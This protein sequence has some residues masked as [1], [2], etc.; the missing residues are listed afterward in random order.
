[1]IDA[2]CIVARTLAGGSLID[3][4]GG[5]EIVKLGCGS[6]FFGESLINQRSQ[7]LD[8]GFHCNEFLLRELSLG[9]PDVTT[10]GDVRDP[11]IHTVQLDL[12]RSVPRLDLIAANQQP[13]RQ[14]LG[15]VRCQELRPSLSP[16]KGRR[17]QA[18]RC[19]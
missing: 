19:G 7:S 15:P 4:P 1:M 14:L 13:P 5:I 2:G 10:L 3:D 16:K 17:E 6:L 11:H 8:F 12:G 18:Q 9:F